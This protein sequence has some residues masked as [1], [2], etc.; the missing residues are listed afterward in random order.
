MK[1]IIALSGGIDST[2]VL[3]SLLLQGYD[4]FPVSFFYGSKHNPYENEA[5]KKIAEHYGLT[6]HLIDVSAVTILFESALLSKGGEIPEG[7]YAG[8]NMRQTVVPSR[9]MIFLTILSGIAESKGISNLA[10][11]VHQGDHFI[12]PDCRPE[13]IK[14]MQQTITLSSAGAVNTILTPILHMDKAQVVKWGVEME[15]PF[16]LTRT[17]YKAQQLACGKCGSCVERLEAFQKNNL[18]DPIEYA[19]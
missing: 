11:G 19:K 12:Y 7:H 17:C 8:E 16:H 6:L 4:V 9:N 14:S 2:V 1:A 10:I 3:R 15:I 18:T 5:A 13:F